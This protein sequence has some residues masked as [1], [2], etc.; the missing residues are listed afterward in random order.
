MWTRIISGTDYLLTEIVFDIIS[1]LALWGCSLITEMLYL[2]ESELMGAGPHMLKP[3][4]GPWM[5]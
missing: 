2:N 1:A 5:S 3:M 4:L